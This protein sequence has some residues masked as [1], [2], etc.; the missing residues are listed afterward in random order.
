M[1][2]R[3]RVQSVALR[4]GLSCIAC[5]TELSSAATR[6]HGASIHVAIS[7]R[8]G[9]TFVRLR[10][11]TI[12]TSGNGDDGDRCRQFSSAPVRLRS[13]PRRVQ[14]FRHHDRTMSSRRTCL[15]TGSSGRNPHRLSTI[16]SSVPVDVAANPLARREVRSPIDRPRITP[17]VDSVDRS[18]LLGFPIA[19]VHKQSRHLRLRDYGPHQIWHLAGGCG[20]ASGVRGGVVPRA[21]RP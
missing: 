15:V 13:A 17:K 11:S 4:G 14:A 19:D 8:C 12:T 6:S 1:G 7:D 2:G 21:Q 16:G 20:A 3:M 5:L 9:L 10:R 18:Q